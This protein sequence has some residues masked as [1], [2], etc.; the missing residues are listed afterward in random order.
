[1]YTLLLVEDEN[2]ARAALMEYVPWREWNIADVFEAANG[3]QALEVAREKAPDFVLTDIRMPEMDGIE[4][5]RRL[6]EELPD[7]YVI[8]LSAY[9]DV[10]YLKAAMKT[11]AVDYLL[12][13]VD[14]AELEQAVQAAIGRKAESEVRKKERHVLERN[15]PLLRERFFLSLLEDGR[16][17]R[18]EIAD[19][20]AS[21]GLPAAD[22][23]KWHVAVFRFAAKTGEAR[24]LRFTPAVREEMKSML[25]Q[26]FRRFEPCH[27]VMN[28]ETE[29]IVLAGV[30]GDTEPHPPADRIAAEARALLENHFEFAVIANVCRTALALADLHRSMGMLEA[31]DAGEGTDSGTTPAEERQTKLVRAI[32][33]Y[34]EERYSDETLTVADIAEHLNYT[35]A[36]VCMAFKRATGLTVNHYM[37]LYRIRMAKRL[38]DDPAIKLYEVAVRVGYSN[39]NYFSKVFKKYESVSPSEYKQ[40]KE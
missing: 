31:A 3:R 13:P 9:S 39:E 20:C 11:R 19:M 12:K 38:L 29:W 27:V 7:T 36:Y 8:M 25:L 4:L 15:L 40:G 37:N 28:G 23:M 21:L 10:A 2:K 24:P 35:S 32:K 16:R 26:A 14:V 5:S 30:H 17:G 33:S 34:I 22:G 18:Q 1:M 6:H